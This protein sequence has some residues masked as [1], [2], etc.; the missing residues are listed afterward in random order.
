M[1]NKEYIKIN[2]VDHFFMEYETEND[3][4]PVVLYVHGGPGVA[5]TLIG[6]DAF[7]STQKK[8]TWVFYDQRGAGRT[9]FNCPDGLVE[10]ESIYD[11]LCE[12]VKVIHLKYNKKIYIMGHGFG[13]I[14][15]IRYV[16]ENPEY[17]AGYIGYSQIVDAPGMLEVRCKRMT[18]IATLANSKG[19]LKKISKFQGRSMD[20]LD[21]KE[22]KKLAALFSKYHM[23][24]SVNKYLLTRISSS[25]EYNL[26]DLKMLLGGQ[27]LS[28]KLNEYQKT[29]N[30]FNEPN[31]YCVPMLFVHG[32]Y[33]YQNPYVLTQKYCE[34]IEAPSTAVSLIK[35]ATANA[36][37]EVQNE[38]WN[39]IMKFVLG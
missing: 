21:K 29:V 28:Y 38:F 13:T 11:D 35:D 3:E 25:P 1:I 39:E 7:L 37:Y 17:V 15:A 34:F 32:D 8:I 12:I 23:T 26:S 18:E 10:Y 16:R 5:E 24:G 9:F 36:M 27:K 31:S 4:S 2:G 14:P 20:D 22:L 19:D 33:D 6:C 30:L